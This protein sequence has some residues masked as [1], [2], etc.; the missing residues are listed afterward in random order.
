MSKKSAE[1]FIEAVVRDAALRR[2]VKAAAGNI[3]K[4]ARDAGFNV[5][6]EEI[7]QALRAFWFEEAGERPS[8]TMFSETPGY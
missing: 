5:T 6:S 3:A 1:A 2:K 8:K 4:V 7:S